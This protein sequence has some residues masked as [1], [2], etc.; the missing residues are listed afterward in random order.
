MDP[1]V[2]V[3]GLGYTGLP[4]AV[5]AARHGLTV[6]GVDHSPARVAEL[7]AVRPGAGRTTV[8]ENELASLLTGPLSVRTGSVPAAKVHLL[9]VPSRD[10]LSAVD[11]VSAVARKGDLVIVQSTCPPGMVDEV[12]L[13][14]ITADVHVAHSPVRINPGK[15]PVVDVPRVV[16]SPSPEGLAAAIRFLR[17]V[18]QAVVP[19]GS[20]RVA[21]L[22]KVFENTFR[23]VNISLANELATV[24]DRSNVDVREVLAAAGTKPYGYLRHEPGPGAGGD[25]VPVCAEFFAAAARRHGFAASTVE[26]AIAVNDSMPTSIARRLTCNGRVLV[27][28]VAYKPGVGDVRRSAAV[29]ILD[30]LRA[31]T[32][33]SYHDPH[34][35]RLALPDGTVLYSQPVRPGRADMVL[36]VTKH[37][38]MDVTGF[39]APVVD[40][41]AGSIVEDRHG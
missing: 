36:L 17:S 11:L 31:R 13:P 20:I 15:E 35:P 12:V 2:V 7:V 3:V 34:V 41:S 14:R 37:E 26:A 6:V 27:A 8:P 23:L 38:D 10:L 16:A 9:C 19:V 30:E 21:E 25:C 5:A 29:R 33:V 39:E 1:D 18:G 40:C 22:T 28:G 24:C 32:E 4:M